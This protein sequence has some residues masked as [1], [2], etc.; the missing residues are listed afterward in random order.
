MSWSEGPLTR[1]NRLR[2][3]V[4]FEGLDGVVVSGKKEVYYFTGS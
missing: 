4:E 1:S 3:L 2:K